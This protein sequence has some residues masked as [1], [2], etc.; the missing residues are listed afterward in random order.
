M[1][2]SREQT[3]GSPGTGPKSGGGFRCRVAASKAEAMRN[4]IA[5]SNGRAMKSTPTGKFA[6]TGPT[7]RVPP[8]PSR[9][10]SQISR[11]KA[12]RYGDRGETLLPD[13]RPANRRTAIRVWF[14]RRRELSRRD[15]GH[16][17]DQRVEPLFLHALQQEILK[18]EAG[19]QSCR[20][21]QHR[22][23]L[24]GLPGLFAIGEIRV[25]IKPC[26]RDQV[27]AGFDVGVSTF[28]QIPVHHVFAF[29]LNSRCIEAAERKIGGTRVGSACIQKCSRLI[30]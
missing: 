30:D 6:L 13:E 15:S 18:G 25:L 29:A 27:R 11:R 24:R 22:G 20:C 26:L 14:A 28:L 3:Y 9:T 4:S 17:G 5:S 10:R 12:C 2:A 8:L 19:L 23:A 16:R 1:E 21:V 7:R